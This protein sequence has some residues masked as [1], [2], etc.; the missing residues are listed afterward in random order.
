MNFLIWFVILILF[1]MSFIALIYP[2]L[3]S[4][5]GVWAGFLL[6]HFFIN[7]TELTTLFWMIMIIFTFVLLLSDIFASSLS[8]KK[9]GGTK[10]GERVAALSVII[11]SFIFPPFGILVIPF[12]AVF[13]VELTQES[14]L[15][16][17]WNSAVGSLV[18]FLKGQIATA[19]I[20]FIMI[21]WFFFT[22]W[23]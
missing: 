5:T 3:P 8:V 1:L 6:Y 4:I 12:L 18:G 13:L 16:E 22:I 15:N 2:V 23:F 20:Q 9:Y 7:S 10:L 14:R 11:G 21:I 17:A 19:I